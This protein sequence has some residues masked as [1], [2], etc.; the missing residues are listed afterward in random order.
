MENAIIEVTGKDKV[1]YANAVALN[2]IEQ[3]G[4]EN[5]QVTVFGEG[6]AVSEYITPDPNDQGNCRTMGMILDQGGEFVAC[7]TPS[8]FI[9]PKGKGD[10]VKL[11]DECSCHAEIKKR[12]QRGDMYLKF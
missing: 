1:R 12:K 7:S 4:E 8:S 9:P 5:V 3:L 2:L 6:S 11:M 10:H